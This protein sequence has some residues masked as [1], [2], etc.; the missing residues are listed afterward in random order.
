MQLRAPRRT[1][2]LTLGVLGAFALAAAAAPMTATATTAPTV[3]APTASTSSVA[4]QA[5]GDRPRAAIGGGCTVTGG[6]LTWGFKESFRSYISGTIA[7]GSWEASAGATYATPDFTWS[8]ATGRID[9]QRGEGQVAFTGL[10]RFSGHGG[11]LDTTI[12]NPVLSITPQGV[13]LLLD[14]SG[15][16]MDDALAGK[17]DAV[18]HAAVPFAALAVD[19]AAIVV[20]GTSAALAAVPATVT[21]EGFAAFGSYEAGTSLDPVSASLT[22]DCTTPEPSPTPSPES[23]PE[24]S[25]EPTATSGAGAVTAAPAASSA[26]DDGAGGAPGWVPWTIAGAVLA[27]LAGVGAVLMIRR[28]GAAGETHDEEAPGDAAGNATDGGADGA[29]D[30]GPEL[31]QDGSGG[32][33]P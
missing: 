19:P 15:V 28:R 18:A 21:P 14:T 10:V 7:N 23:S 13:T 4:A 6:T 30:A 27:G 3:Q 32:P 1:I 2:P 17:T 24:P 25:P 8:G 12:A 26:T 9:P 22:L 11:L 16:S 31:P 29:S 5:P 33:R 20:D